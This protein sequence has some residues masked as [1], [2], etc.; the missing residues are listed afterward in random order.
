MPYISERGRSMPASPIRKL[1][2]CAEAAKRRGIEVI[3]LNIGQPDMHTPKPALAAVQQARI[4]VLAY[5]QSEGP[6]RF[7]EKWAAYYQKIGCDIHADQIVATTGGSEALCLAFGA[8]MDAGDEVIVPEPLY[9]NYNGFANSS[10]VRI[11]PVISAL[12]SGFALPDISD[13]ERLISARTR[14]VLICNPSNPTG[15]LY[16]RA[17]LEKL[18]DLALKHDLFLIADEVYREFVYD[19][20]AQHSLL[21][22]AGLDDCA[23]VVDSLSKRYS[24]CGARVGCV[25]SRNAA[26]RDAITRFAQ[27]RLSPPALGLLVGEAAL[28][29]PQ[30]YFDE[31]VAAYEHRRNVLVESLNA[32]EGVYTPKP[33]GAFYCVARLPV[34][35]ADQFTQW[36]LEDFSLDGKTVMLA[37]ASGFYTEPE[38]GRD[39]VRIAYV[40]KAE[41]LCEAVRIL[42]AALKAYNS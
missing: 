8:I 6:L 38:C 29:T 26:L 27:A 36:L 1:V 19:G 15:Y 21:S 16:T 20:R 37:P 40:R 31:V 22:F 5:S 24:M 11:V 7:R 41:I 14:A 35:D 28:D 34:D 4:E 25:V 9:A 12:E 33:S 42:D 2:P 17:E 3:H 13:F 18:A 23:I 10:N 39:Q 30:S 32:V